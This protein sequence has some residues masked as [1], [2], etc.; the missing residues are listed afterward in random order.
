[1]AEYIDVSLQWDEIDGL[2]L[3][4]NDGDSEEV[5]KLDDLVEEAIDEHRTDGDYRHLYCLAH[6]LNRLQEI[7]REA[8]QMMEDDVA[9]RYGMDPEDL[10]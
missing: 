9:T 8:A 3:A 4:L 6:D 1:M 5:L 7:I 10:E 2:H